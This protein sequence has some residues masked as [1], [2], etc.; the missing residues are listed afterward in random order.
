MRKLLSYLLIIA[1]SS[2]AVPSCV[3]ASATSH[4]A[5]ASAAGADATPP[6]AK[7]SEAAV[8]LNPYDDLTGLF[9]DAHGRN[10]YVLAAAQFKIEDMYTYSFESAVIFEG[11]QALAA[12]VLDAGR[13]PGLGVR[14]LHAQGITGENVNVAI[15]DQNLLTGHP[16]YADRIAAY[17]DAGCETPANEGSYHAPSVVSLLAGKTLGTAPG[18]NVYFAATP[19][20]KKDAAYSADCLQWIIEQNR[21]L[22]DGEKIR[23]VSVSSAP[24]E[25]WYANAEMWDAAVEDAT[26]EGIL[27]MDCR[28]QA[29]T[30]FVF[31]A[32]Y[33][34]DDPEDVT[35]CTP[36]YPDI[37]HDDFAHDYWSNTVFAPASY[38]T[39]ARA[40]T[41]GDNRYGYDGSGGQSWAVP[42]VA[43]VMALGFQVRPDLTG[44][45]MKDL[46]FQSCWTD[47]DGVHFIDPP[48]FIEAVRNAPV[49]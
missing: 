27:V 11:A 21:A 40:Y 49:R 30:G 23:L 9:Y 22:P 2:L 48:R 25:G 19:S 18:A 14:D 43:G 17:Y 42:Y 8:V 46:L 15:I 32:Y 35:K 12:D 13:N 24:E 36:G 20:W 6:P 26:R 39:M 41:A 29:E 3:N 38:R 1:L 4:S 44:Q 28:S 7:A 31:S 47:E 10:G 37:V 5:L 45:E 16:E 33:D 34:R